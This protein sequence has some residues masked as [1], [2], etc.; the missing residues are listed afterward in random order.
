MSKHA[1]VLYISKSSNPHYS[2]SEVYESHQISTYL[3]NT[4]SFEECLQM[5]SHYCRDPCPTNQG[6]RSPIKHRNILTFR[7]FSKVFDS[8]D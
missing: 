6:P 2:L 1:S 5:A 7:C 4:T 3:S 8:M